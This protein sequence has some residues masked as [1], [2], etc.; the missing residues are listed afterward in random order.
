MTVTTIPLDR[1]PSCEG[2]T[3]GLTNDCYGCSQPQIGQVGNFI[4]AKKAGLPVWA[5][6]LIAIAGVGIAWKVFKR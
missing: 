4:T 3:K 6:V 5:W 2:C 1:N